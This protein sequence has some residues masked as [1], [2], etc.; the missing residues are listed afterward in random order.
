[1]PQVLALQCL[2]LTQRL[3]ALLVSHGCLP[4]LRCRQQE[5]WTAELAR[6]KAAHPTD[7][8]V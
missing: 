4:D 6:I 3:Q 5:L 7:S 8:L 1:M 2:G